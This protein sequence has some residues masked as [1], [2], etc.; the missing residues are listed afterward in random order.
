MSFEQKIKAKVSF[1]QKS[2]RKRFELYNYYLNIKNQ[3]SIVPTHRVD[4][5]FTYNLPAN[6]L[7]IA[8]MI[9]YL[10]GL[11]SNETLLERL[12]FITDAKEENELVREEEA[13]RKKTEIEKI[14]EL[15]ARGY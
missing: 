2:L 15:S 10:T 1:F 11:V 6:E 4:I 14:E 9:S 3:M 7:E 5:V 13:E 12:P 8:Q